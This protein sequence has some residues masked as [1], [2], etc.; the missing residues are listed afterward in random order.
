MS[1]DWKLTCA[2]AVSHSQNPRALSLM[3]LQQ[4]SGL[5]GSMDWDHERGLINQRPGWECWTALAS[6]AL[7]GRSA[8][9]F[10][11]GWSWPLACVV[12]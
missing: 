3:M 11:L 5:S 7:L 6:P 4:A 8:G 1:F 2:S 10:C 9:L 12:D